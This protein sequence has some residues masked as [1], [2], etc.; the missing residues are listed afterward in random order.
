MDRINV[1]Q[2]VDSA[3]LLRNRLGSTFYDG[4]I[5]P[6]FKTRNF[7]I[8][9]QNRHYLEVVCSLEQPSSDSSPFGIAVSHR[10]AESGSWLTW[11]VAV[12]HVSMIEKRLGRAAVDG[13]RTKLDEKVLAWRQIGVLGTI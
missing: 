11:V 8:R 6:L 1:D 4:G 13:H 12:D 9:I 3:Q 10:A 5:Y 2:L 7:T